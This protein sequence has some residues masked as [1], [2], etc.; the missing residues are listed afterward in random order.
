MTKLNQH[1][2]ILPME[3]QIDL[4]HIKIHLMYY[5]TQHSDWYIIRTQVIVV[6]NGIIIPPY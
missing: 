4:I 1:S 6:I 3:V 2:F 5:S